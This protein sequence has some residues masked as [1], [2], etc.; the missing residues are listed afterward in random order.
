[1]S[2]LVVLLSY[3]IARCFFFISFFSH[4]FEPGEQ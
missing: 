4:Q 2:A 3:L 1:V